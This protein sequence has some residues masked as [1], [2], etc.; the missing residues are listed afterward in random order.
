MRH[1]FF[2]LFFVLLLAYAIYYIIV[3]NSDANS[4]EQTSITTI[5]THITSDLD[6]AMPLINAA[7]YDMSAISVKSSLPPL[8]IASFVL[9]EK[10]PFDNQESILKAL[11]GNIIGKLA[12]KSLIQA[13]ELDE[14]LEFKDKELKVIRLFLTIPP[15]V[16][17]EYR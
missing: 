16:Q 17:V 2:G 4:L 9:T 7:G 8:V 6:D 15:A 3:N 1:F 14:T 5:V 13:F 10:V 12:L 11:E